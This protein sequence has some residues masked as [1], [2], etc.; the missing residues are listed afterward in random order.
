MKSRKLCFQIELET[1]EREKDI[2]S[3]IKDMLDRHFDQVEV[4]RGNVIKPPK[5]P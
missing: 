1:A 4:S 2:R 3:D 5:K